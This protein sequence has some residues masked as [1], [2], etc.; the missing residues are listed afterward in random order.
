[1]FDDEVCCEKRKTLEETEIY[2]A[3]KG[4]YGRTEHDLMHVFD[5]ILEVGDRVHIV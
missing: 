3:E 1:M 4:L 2:G 5:P